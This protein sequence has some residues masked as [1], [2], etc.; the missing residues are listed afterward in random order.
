VDLWRGRLGLAGA[1]EL[2]PVEERRLFELQVWALSQGISSLIGD[3]GPYE[4]CR[5]AGVIERLVIDPQRGVIE[6][7]LNDGT[8]TVLAQWLIRRPTPELV[9]TPGQA[10]VLHGVAATEAQGDLVI[11]EPAF[12]IVPFPEVA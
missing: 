1:L 11:R 2:Q 12:E 6:I 10:A 3:L 5:I 4:P 7:S 8:G 9:L